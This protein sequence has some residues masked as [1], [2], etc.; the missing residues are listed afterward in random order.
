MIEVKREWLSHACSVAEEGLALHPRP[1][2]PPEVGFI[3]PCFKLRACVSVERGG[4]DCVQWSGM[5][6]RGCQS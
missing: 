4:S 1:P 2:S 6:H 5:L 3:L